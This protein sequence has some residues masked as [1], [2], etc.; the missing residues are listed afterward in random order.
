MV[1]Y[2]CTVV[3]DVGASFQRFDCMRVVGSC[4]MF[5]IQGKILK[6]FLLWDSTAS[7]HVLECKFW[8]DGIAAV[9]SDLSVFTAEVC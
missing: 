8:G 2:S 4:L 6:Q 1:S 9:A 7:V 5:N 3:V